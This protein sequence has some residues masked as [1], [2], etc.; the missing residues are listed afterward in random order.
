MLD[1]PAPQ[2]CVQALEDER[3]QLLLDVEFIR[4][5]LDGEYEYRYAGTHSLAL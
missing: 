1:P 3:D 4:Q 2:N 5:A